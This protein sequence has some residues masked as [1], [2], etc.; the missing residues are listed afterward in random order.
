MRAPRFSTVLFDLDGTLANTLGL[1]LGSY[2][3]ALRAHGLEVPAEVEM[4]RWIGRTLVD[5]FTERHPEQ[6][7]SIIAE[8]TRWNVAH[9]P[10]LVE[11]Y[12]GVAD[13]LA[14]LAARGVRVAVATS[15]R[16]A[17]AEATLAAVGL[18][19][20]VRVAA[21][22]EDT[23]AHKP[24]PD[25]LLHALDVLEADAAGAAY[26][27]D[28]GVDLAAADAAGVAGIGVTW[29][30]GTRAELAAVPHA[31]VA[32]SPAELRALLL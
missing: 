23:P 7:A 30:A 19:G 17:S 15:K 16:R 12:P 24:A 4:R 1:I 22:M 14:D 25:P 27:G 28:A 31:A 13:L 29:G 32:T 8:Y 5:I 11:P 6:A 26:V 2:A 20:L 3:H 10:T 9:L 21:A 18:D